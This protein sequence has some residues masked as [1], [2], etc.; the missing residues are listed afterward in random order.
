MIFA[1]RKLSLHYGI[2]LSMMIVIIHVR[3]VTVDL[4]LTRCINS[5]L[6][7]FL[8]PLRIYFCFFENEMYEKC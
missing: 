7:H 6:S 3:T 2:V 1:G 5:E 8:L 4:I